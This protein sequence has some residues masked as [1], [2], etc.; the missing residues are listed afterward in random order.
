MYGIIRGTKISIESPRYGHGHDIE[1]GRLHGRQNQREDNNTDGLSLEHTDIVAADTMI[2]PSRPTH[3]FAVTMSQS[4]S[5][6]GKNRRQ[7]EGQSLLFIS[8]DTAQFRRSNLRAIVSHARKTQTQQK[9][10]RQRESAQQNATYARSLVG[11]QQEVSVNVRHRSNV[12]PKQET[13]DI[14]ETRDPAPTKKKIDYDEATI[15]FQIDLPVRGGLRSDPFSSFPM[16][17]LKEAM[18]MIDF[19]EWMSGV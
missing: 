8:Q 13:G 1:P 14:D 10:T 18:E 9:H 15:K 5:Q 11:W 2:V 16:D 3:N 6:K 12:E 4:S 17:N 7:G 19:C